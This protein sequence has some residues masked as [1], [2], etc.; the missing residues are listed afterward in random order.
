VWVLKLYDADRVSTQSFRAMFCPCILHKT[1]LTNYVHIFFISK[2]KRI[3][4]IGLVYLHTQTPTIRTY[5]IRNLK[6]I[7]TF[8]P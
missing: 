7:N 8:K 3:G 2:T 1:M 5:T 4:V 6:S